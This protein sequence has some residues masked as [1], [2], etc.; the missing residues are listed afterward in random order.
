V[1]G[2]RGGLRGTEEMDPGEVPHQRRSAKKVYG[3]A[4]W[5]R[6]VLQIPGAPVDRCERHKHT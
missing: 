3:I 6:R 2:C 1:A 5:W 4:R